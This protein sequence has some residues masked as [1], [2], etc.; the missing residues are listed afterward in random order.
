ESTQAAVTA[1]PHA[2]A[3]I[4]IP[5]VPNELIDTI[6]KG[7][8]TLFWG[9][10]LS[11]QAGYPT[12]REALAYMIDRTDPESSFKSDLQKQLTA[13]RFPLVLEALMARLTRTEIIRQ[14]SELWGTPR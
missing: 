1:A 4:V 11:A 8:C 3:P 6:S 5:E 10:G 14:L 12:W 13:G 7:E 9:G 2:S